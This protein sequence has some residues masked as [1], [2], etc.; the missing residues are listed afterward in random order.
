MTRLLRVELGRLVA[1]KVVWVTLL[2]AVAIVLVTLFGV[3]TQARQIDHARSGA[4][5]SYQQMVEDNE[6]M[7]EECK[8]EEAQERRRSGDPSVDFSCEQMR[9]PSI[10]DMYGQMPALTDQYRMLLTG[11]VYPFAF[12]ALAMGST[13]VAAEFSHRTMG[14]LLTF[15]PRRTRVFVAKVVAPALAAVPMTVVGMVLVLLGVPAVFRWF[16]LDDGVPADDWRFLLWM[17]L[18]VVVVAALAGAF[19][20]A[21]AFLVKHS[22]VVIGVLVGYLVLAEGFI[23]NMF[24]SVQRFLLG[25]NIDAFV[26]DGAQWESWD[27]CTGFS[28]CVPVKHSITGTHGAV[29]LAVLLAAVALL[30]WARF[31]TADVD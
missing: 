4:D 2:A 24:F 26:N 15:E 6:R 21:A 27:N 22:G 17:A 16:H 11:L 10:E 7:I 1:R 30:A 20:A 9:P 28:E 12:L 19:G 3:F 13:A 5:A 31:R 14:T 29:E 23:G 25:R 8:L 18:R